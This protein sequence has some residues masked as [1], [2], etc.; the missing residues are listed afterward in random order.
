M[1]YNAGMRLI[2]FLILF[3][4][5]GCQPTQ[6]TPRIPLPVTP[7][8]IATEMATVG[9][10]S[11]DLILLEQ[12]NY[13]ESQ[14]TRF[15]SATLTH[16]TLFDVPENGWINQIAQH[17]VDGRL[18]LAYTPPAA[19]GS[20]RLDRSGLYWLIDGELTPLLMPATPNIYY[21]TPTFS[22]DGTMLFF[23][24]SIIRGGGIQNLDVTLMRYDMVTGEQIEL[25]KDG[26]WPRVSA[27][28][29][30]LAHVHV[31]VP[32]LQRSL[33]ISRLDGSERRVLIP[34]GRYFDLDTPVF[35]QDSRTLYFTVAQYAPDTRSLLDKLTGVRTAHAHANQN[36]PS[37]WWQIDVMGGVE[38][39]I[40]AETDIILHG[41]FDANGETLYFSTVTGLYAFPLATGEIV[42]L[43]ENTAFRTVLHA[44]NK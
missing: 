34:Q 4:C 37:A 38:E 2:L 32:S 15:E 19:D 41:S 3:V 12:F 30:W 20:L 11:A 21:Y 13:P 39:Q 10:F 28:G 5:V 44:V 22:P 42:R 36:I 31:H 1:G 43:E 17:P 8:P 33:V 26:I 24:R 40:S 7:A 6:T 9:E 25:D 27:D 23:V 18:L 16:E 29:Q 35:S 14:I